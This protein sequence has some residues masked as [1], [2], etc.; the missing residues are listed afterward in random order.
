MHIEPLSTELIERYLHLRD[1][2]FFRDDDGDFL[3]LFSS[4]RCQ[5]HVQMAVSGRDRDVLTI[6]VSHA[7]YYAA[8]DRGRLSELVNE[9]NRDT[10]WP[11][12]FVRETSNP[13]RVSVIGELAYPLTRGIHLEALTTF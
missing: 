5:L 3:L 8:S 11:K 7:D 1:F 9:W 4:E 13:S 12:A 6:R 2:R 10:H